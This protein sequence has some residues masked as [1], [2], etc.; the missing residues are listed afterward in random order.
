MKLFAD[1]KSSKLQK[2]LQ[3]QEQLLYEQE[4][5]R[6][7]AQID[8]DA[9]LAKKLQE[10][11]N[12]S[13]GNVSPQ[14]SRPPPLPSRPPKPLAYFPEYLPSHDSD[15][16]PTTPTTQSNLPFG[17]LRTTSTPP[18]VDSSTFP[19]RNPTTRVSPTERPSNGRSS[20]PLY[21]PTIAPS[22]PRPASTQVY[23]HLTTSPPNPSASAPPTFPRRDP[24]M[25]IIPTSVNSTPAPPHNSRVDH[26]SVPI[27]TNNT[28]P[29]YSTM[30]STLPSNYQYSNPPY[31]N[32]HT[33]EHP[34][35]QGAPDYSQHQSMPD[36]SHQQSMPDY[37]YQQTASSYVHQQSAHDYMHQQSTQVT[38]LHNNAHVS[39]IVTNTTLI[40]HQVSHPTSRP[41]FEG[42][43][44]KIEKPNDMTGKQEDEQ[45]GSRKTSASQNDDDDSD[46]D[47][48]GY[49]DFV[50]RVGPMM[51]GTKK[52]M[53]KPKS[54][55]TLGGKESVEKDHRVAAHPVDPVD[56]LD[57]FA[58]THAIDGDDLI[59]A[60]NAQGSNAGLKSESLLTI[61]S[62]VPRPSLA[63]TSEIS[64][65]E[66]A[67]NFRQMQQRLSALLQGD[68]EQTDVNR[69]TVTLASV[70]EKD[71]AQ[72]LESSTKMENE[73]EE[74][75][76]DEKVEIVKELTVGVANT[77][78]ALHSPLHSRSKSTPPEQT[79]L[80]TPMQSGRPFHRTTQAPA[81]LRPIVPR[82]P[83]ARH[84]RSKSF[85]DSPTSPSA[86]RRYTVAEPS[87]YPPTITPSLTSMTAQ[88]KDV[89]A[90]IPQNEFG[91]Y[92]VDTPKPGNPVL[93]RK[94]LPQL[95][96]NLPQGKSENRHITCKLPK[97]FTA[98][99][100]VWIA[101]KP[102]DTGKTLAQ[103]IHVV[104][105]FRTMKITGLRT[106]NGR[107][108][109]LDN[110]PV[111]AT[112]DEIENFQDGELW[113]FETGGEPENFLIQ[114][115]MC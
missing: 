105:T 32:Y 77:P 87:M 10:E 111:F 108:V 8:E 85:S 44:Y 64:R 114:G 71:E 65:P 97:Q 80:P 25:F 62:E 100:R 99:H 56:L 66:S 43:S 54:S 29:S 92:R 96:P 90:G 58:D 21:P 86:G 59:S 79:P 70:A 6:R 13:R 89:L 45:G 83:T 26:M 101:V 74:R 9:R 36:Y 48:D 68:P 67:A 14:D 72:P 115:G 98:G 46:S 34:H 88:S 23:P 15:P 53:A 50:V 63:V 33:P 107:Q 22:P 18:A 78:A 39:S 55:V 76:P 30:A 28:H 57:P 75:E 31:N 109:P 19:P 2:K 16:S 102:S 24:V 1:N 95:P 73:D 81:T 5:F 112:W 52:K 3:R 4:Q 38:Q 35:H 91:F 12:T 17:R 94:A 27:T 47:S 41:Q 49:T 11:E 103:R 69:S 110:T 60:N 113:T 106:A 7:L 40:N 37:T 51:A 93:E 42:Q 104:A 20:P 84:N 61:A 82:T